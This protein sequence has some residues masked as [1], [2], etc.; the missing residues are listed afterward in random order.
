MLL[1]DRR[2][3]IYAICQKYDIILIE[4]DPYWHLQ[5]RFDCPPQRNPNWRSSGFE[6]LDSLVPSYLSLDTDGRVV[7][8]D[9]FSKSIAPGARLGWLTAQ[10]RIV[11]RILRISET[12][13]QQPSGFVQSMV[14]SLL[15]GNQEVGS[16]GK[17]K[18][19][20]NQGWDA[21]GWVRWLEGLRTSYEGRMRLMC[22]ILE[23]GKYAVVQGGTTTAAATATATSSNSHG[24]HHSRNRSVDE[25]E[26]VDKV[27]VLEFDWPL[28]GMFVWV[29]ACLETHPLAS[30]TTEK[31]LSGALWKHLTKEPY[32]CVV[33][34]GWLFAPTQEMKERSWPYM[35][36]CFAPVDEKDLST[37]SHALVEGVHSFWQVKDLDQ[38]QDGD[39]PW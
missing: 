4:D 31:I 27:Q 22:S 18:L 13:T 16:R 5:Y 35:R 9:T 8:L 29:K 2:R 19:H 26:V 12:S 37:W 21:S 38:I 39:E 3:E 14:A 36:L 15:I 23:D 10:P 30:Q 7:R 32:L 1:I 28:A 24:L 6:F 17:T 33:A 20:Q 11:E 25:W 34:P